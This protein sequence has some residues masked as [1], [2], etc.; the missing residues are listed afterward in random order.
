MDFKLFYF[1][2]LITENDSDLDRDMKSRLLKG[3]E[4]AN[5][6]NLKFHGWQEAFETFTGAFVFTDKKT[7][8][9]FFAKDENEAEQNLN[10]MRL[11]FKTS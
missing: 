11:K 5:K 2:K 9:T 4:I 3:Q 6:L 8:S 1:S 10:K 7:R